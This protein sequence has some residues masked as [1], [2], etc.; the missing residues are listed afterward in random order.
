M[1]L[2]DRV[3]T[4]NEAL[5]VAVVL[6]VVVDAAVANVVVFTAVVA[7]V[8]TFAFDAERILCGESGPAGRERILAVEVT[9]SASTILRTLAVPPVAGDGRPLVPF[10]VVVINV[11]KRF[12]LI[13]Y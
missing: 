8:V 11:Y 13:F 12:F 2:D 10:C 3:T 6:D 7:V 1:L 9:P 4:N 5:S